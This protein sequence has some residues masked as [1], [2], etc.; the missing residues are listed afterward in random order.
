MSTDRPFRNLVLYIGS[1]LVTAV[2]GFGSVLVLTRLLAPADYGLVGIFLSLLFLVA[3]LVSVSADGLIAVNKST[4]TLTAYQS[5]QSSYIAIAYICFFGLQMAFL[6]AWLV[7]FLSDG[8]LLGLALFGLIRFLAGMASTEYVVEERAFLFSVMTIFNSLCSLLL[9]VL[10]IVTFGSW[11]GWRIIAMLVADLFMLIIRYKGRLHLLFRPQLQ[12]AEL[13]PIIAFG[14]PGL[15][16]VSGSWALNEA[17]KV[18]VA[19]EAGLHQAGIYTA[20]AGLA[21]IMMIFNQSL[22]NALYPEMFRR[23]S[24]DEKSHWKT[25]LHYLFIF[26]TLA[27][28]FGALTVAAYL[29]LGDLLLPPRYAGSRDVFI[30]LVATGVVVSIYRPFGL[31]A[32]YLKWGRRRALAITLGGGLTL[33]VGFLG[34][35]HGG[36]LWAPAGVAI[37]YMCA[38]LVLAAGLIR[39]RKCHE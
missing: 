16:A 38:A 9:T 15:I 27:S 14:M 22:T 33:L 7:G 5:F 19:H 30:A 31:L 32:E 35:R 39:K 8:L 18:I 6:I 11:G 21:G 34:V 12:R 10:F 17:D 29:I 26:G 2:I 20:A 28:C 1:S 4:L 23:L 13:R 24:L 36:L 25:V 3:P 37:G